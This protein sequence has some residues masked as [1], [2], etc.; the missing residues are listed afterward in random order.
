MNVDERTHL[1]PRGLSNAPMQLRSLSIDITLQTLFPL[2]RVAPWL[3]VVS[4]AASQQEGPGFDYDCGPF[5]VETACPSRFQ[6][7]D[8]HIGLIGSSKSR[9]GQNVSEGLLGSAINWQ[10]LQEV[11]QPSPH[12]PDCRITVMG[13]G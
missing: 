2:F 7:K 4:T 3:A 11:T 5:C 6:F 12:D 10:L 8:M 9:E 13:N 1:E